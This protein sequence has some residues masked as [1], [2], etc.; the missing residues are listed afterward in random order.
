MNAPAKGLQILLLGLG[1]MGSAMGA[2]LVA[3]GHRVAGVTRGRSRASRDRAAAAGIDAVDCASDVLADADLVFSMLHPDQAEEV[4]LDVARMAMRLGASTTFVECNPLAPDRIRR[5]EAAFA[6]GPSRL[7]D[8]AISGLPPTDQRLPILYAA[9]AALGP[10]PQIDGLAFEMRGLGDEIGRASTLKILQN[11]AGRGTNTVLAHTLMLAEDAGLLETLVEEMDLVQKA[12]LDRARR[13]IPWI[14]ADA[15]RFAREGAESER[16]AAEL[17]RPDTFS[18]AI[19]EVMEA[20][21][22]PPFGHETRSDRDA[23]RSAE[24]TVRRIAKATRK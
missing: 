15:Q 21:A 24:E 20:F 19:V 7:V 11:L 22:G 2:R 8:A 17:G 13:S 18:R 5:I 1:E 3:H 12:L 16:L 6:A 23:G 4:A 14:P 10:L 9:G